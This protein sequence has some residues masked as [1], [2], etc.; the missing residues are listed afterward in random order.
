MFGCSNFD[1]NLKEE[2]HAKERR[3][4]IAPPF[5]ENRVLALAELW[6][7]IPDQARETTLQT[8]SQ[9][10]VRQITATQEQTEVPHED[11]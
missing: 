11:C 8:L 1:K 2:T 4:A 5:Q 6:E 7:I 3:E 10:V 9:I